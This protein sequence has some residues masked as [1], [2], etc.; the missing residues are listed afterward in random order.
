MV[1]IH[2]TCAAK[3]A[4][5]PAHVQTLR[6]ELTRALD[7]VRTA[8]GYALDVSLVEMSSTGTA[9]ML[10]VRVEVRAMLSDAR[11]RVRYA[12]TSRATARGQ[13]RDRALLE[14]DAVAAAAHDVARAVRAH[15][16]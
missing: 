16:R 6:G 8:S 15:A 9:S 13:A 12:A 4:R 7:G 1:T 2:A 5:E 14:R 10:D 11:G 3:L